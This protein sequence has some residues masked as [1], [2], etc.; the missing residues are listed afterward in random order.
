MTTSH[1]DPGEQERG[2]R[3][4][5][6]RAAPLTAPGQGDLLSE[7]EPQQPPRGPS[8]GDRRKEK[9]IGKHEASSRAPLIRMLRTKLMFLY[10]ERAFDQR[11]NPAADVYVT[12]D[13]ARRILE[14]SG[15]KETDD[16]GKPVPLNW[17]GAIFQKKAGWR[18][19]G[20]TVPSLHPDANARHVRCW[21][22]EGQ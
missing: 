21:R 1:S 14:R 4:K 16:D 2:T 20:R 11:H 17:F 18:F 5:P 19:T 22:W 3:R 13:D 15:I 8:E 9:A 7:P 6:R 12:A 10:K